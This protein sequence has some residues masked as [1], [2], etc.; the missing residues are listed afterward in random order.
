MKINLQFTTKQLFVAI[1]LVAVA[2][3]T[4]CGIY[5]HWTSRESMAAYRPLNEL[6]E[7]HRRM[8]WTIVEAPND[9]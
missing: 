8:G 3:A 4:M 5:T 7:T 9:G 1:T 6:L 2:L